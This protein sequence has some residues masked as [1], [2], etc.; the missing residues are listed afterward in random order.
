[1]GLTK[2][3]GGFRKMSLIGIKRP[4][5]LLKLARNPVLTDAAQGRPLVFAAPFRAATA[6]AWSSLFVF[7]QAIRQR[8]A[9]INPSIRKLIACALFVVLWTSFAFGQTVSP[10][11]RQTACSTATLSGPYAFHITGQNIFLN[12]LFIAMGRFSSDGQGRISGTMM[13]SVAGHIDK[14]SFTGKYSVNEDCT[15]KATFGISNTI[16]AHLYF[17]IARN[18]DEAELLVAD[19]GTAESGSAVRQTSSIA[20]CP[21]GTVPSADRASVPDTAKL[22][23]SKGQPRN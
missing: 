5:S 13:Q 6:W 22:K 9:V 16:A 2:I 1:M 12:L 7:R 17:V 10:T 4:R 21:A 19:P 23:H 3:M 18:G 11:P 8:A 14:L 20:P 15:G